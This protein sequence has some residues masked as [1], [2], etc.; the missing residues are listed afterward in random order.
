MSSD[1]EEY[2]REGN[3]F[4]GESPVA[5]SS[6][7]DE[8]SSSTTSSDSGEG[9]SDPLFEAVDK[10]PGTEPEVLMIAQRRKHLPSFLIDE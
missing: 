2:G 5:V 9:E 7:T 4:D 8:S 6:S 1:D 10:Y 3:A